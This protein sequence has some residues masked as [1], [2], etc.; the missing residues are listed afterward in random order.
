MKSLH[1]LQL[2]LLATCLA[3]AMLYPATVNAEE[4]KAEPRRLPVYVQ[5]GPK[6][7]SLSGIV[8]ATKGRVVVFEDGRSFAVT[9]ETQ[10]FSTTPFDLVDA[11]AAILRPKTALLAVGKHDKEGQLVAVRVNTHLMNVL[12]G[13]P[14]GPDRM[15]WGTTA[16]VEG[17]EGDRI[18]L[19]QNRFIPIDKQT[20]FYI[21]TRTELVP[22]D[23]SAVNKGATIGFNISGRPAVLK[24]EEPGVVT[25]LF[26]TVRKPAEEVTK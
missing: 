15:E 24:G 23:R 17:V 10:Y 8:K 25:V 20:K 26:V 12:P 11:T 14:S 2:S 7:D 5:P 4:K 6:E 1:S 19:D 22:S 16:V 21:N 3:S 9:E 13:P 18:L